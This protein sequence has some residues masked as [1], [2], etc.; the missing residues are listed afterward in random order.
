M[1][2]ALLLASTGGH[3]AQLVRLEPTLG[4]SE[5][6]LWITFKTPQSESLLKDKR[7]VLYVPYIRSRDWRSTL[8]V[9]MIIARVLRSEK[10]DTAIST[11]AALAVAALPQARLRGVETVYIESV[12]RVQGPSMTGRIIETLRAARLYTQHANWATHRWAP[13]PSVLETY[14]RVAK[15]PAQRPSL[16]VTLG[17][18]EGY[19]FDSLV[20]AILSTG[21]ADERT[22]WQLGYTKRADDLPGQVFSVLESDQFDSFARKADVVVSHAGV[23]SLINL[24]DQGIAPVLAVRRKARGEHVDDHQS[25]IA[26][27]AHSQ[28]VAIAADAEDISADM[29]VRA[30]GLA[31]RD[32]SSAGVRG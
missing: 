14:T 2:K 27:L 15:K 24:L 1:K 3:L 20:D 21:L 16:F 12:S 4:L 30:S 11:G 6:S 9:G 23:G 29:V 31:V 32:G 5:D 18:I 17:T 22:V 28:G 8:K 13:H 7:R 19:R 25:Q 10:F 26:D